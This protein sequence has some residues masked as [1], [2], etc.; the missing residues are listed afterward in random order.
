MVRW[1]IRELS[2]LEPGGVGGGGSVVRL[3]HF[4]G[5]LDDCFASIHGYRAGEQLLG[6]PVLAA[7]ACP[8]MNTVK[9][10]LLWLSKDSK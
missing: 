4:T 1:K 9:W 7:W 3:L 6:G 5:N 10:M 8:S 2:R